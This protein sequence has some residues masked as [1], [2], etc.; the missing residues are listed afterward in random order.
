M[1]LEEIELLSLIN[2]L[3]CVRRTEKIN[4]TD[5]VPTDTVLCITEYNNSVEIIIK[6]CVYTSVSDVRT[7]TADYF[8]I[9]FL[10]LFLKQNFQIIFL[11]NTDIYVKIFVLRK[12]CNIKLKNSHQW[13]YCDMENG[14]IN[15]DAIDFENVRDNGELQTYHNALRRYNLLG[16]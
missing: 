14:S 8:Y 2:D 11:A 5:Y 4:E 1:P 12:S 13:Q 3:K 7:T 15:E 10:S 9:F 6:Y 16:I